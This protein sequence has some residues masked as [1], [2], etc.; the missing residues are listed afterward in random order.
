MAPLTDVS[1]I[2]VD[3][4][5]TSGNV[6]SSITEI[7][8]KSVQIPSSGRQD[9]ASSSGTILELLTPGSADISTLVTILILSVIVPQLVVKVI[10]RD[11][12]L[13]PIT[14]PYVVVVQALVEQF[15]IYIRIVLPLLL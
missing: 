11:F 14:G 3:E 7:I 4:V 5:R 10:D 13:G 6:S 8:S 15:F 2:Q 12:S 1:S 9:V